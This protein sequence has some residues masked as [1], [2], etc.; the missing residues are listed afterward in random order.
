M[1]SNGTVVEAL[2]HASSPCKGCL[3]KTIVRQFETFCL[4]KRPY[5]GAAVSVTYVYKQQHG[6]EYTPT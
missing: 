2:A 1:A 5:V 3:S 6:E 4:Y